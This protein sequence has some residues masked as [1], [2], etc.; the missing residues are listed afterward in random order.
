MG[1]I[2]SVAGVA[3]PIRNHLG[4]VIAGVEIRLISPSLGNKRKKQLITDGCETGR[5]ISTGLGYQPE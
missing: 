5:G 1:V 2:D 3:A 4:K